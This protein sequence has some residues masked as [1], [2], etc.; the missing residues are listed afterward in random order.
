MFNLKDCHDRNHIRYVLQYLSE[1]YV[2]SDTLWCLVNSHWVPACPALP[3]LLS[4]P[5]I[6]CVYMHDI[7][8]CV[9]VYTQILRERL[10]GEKVY[11]IASEQKDAIWH[12]K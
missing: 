9:C 12:M 3:L 2:L 10:G 8:M 11:V 4:T 1:E 6:V 5:L 7:C